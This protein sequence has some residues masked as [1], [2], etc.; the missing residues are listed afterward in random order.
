MSRTKPTRGTGRSA[1]LAI[2]VAIAA[3]GT[4]TACRDDGEGPVAGWSTVDPMVN[5]PIAVGVRPYELTLDL[6]KSDQGLSRQQADDARRF[7]RRYRLQGATALAIEMPEW[8]RGS[9]AEE[10]LVALLVNE[11]V[12]KRSIRY[13]EPGTYGGGNDITMAFETG[14]V[15]HPPECGYWP[16]NLSESRDSTPYWNFGCAQSR[17]L[18]MMVANPNDL[19]GPRRT[20]ARPSDRRDVIYKKFIGGED[21]TAS[22]TEIEQKADVSQ[23]Q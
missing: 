15:A 1:L 23:N 7:F 17:N 19:I 20:S 13:V 12:P 18:A 14:Y 21:T 22:T 8:A 11:A 4:L 16:D 9:L 10:Q 3:T 5:H 6:D 2:A